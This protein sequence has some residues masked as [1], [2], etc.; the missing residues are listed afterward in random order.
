VAH[1]RIQDERKD[2]HSSNGTTQIAL[3]YQQIDPK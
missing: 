1:I 3:G 2:A